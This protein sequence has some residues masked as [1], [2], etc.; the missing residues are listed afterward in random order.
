MVMKMTDEIEKIGVLSFNSKEIVVT[1]ADKIKQLMQSLE[2]NDRVILEQRKDGCDE[3]ELIFSSN[4]LSQIK[5]GDL[6]IKGK[7][8]ENK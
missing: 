3:S 8:K 5:T 4:I 2:D 1:S 6:V 7:E